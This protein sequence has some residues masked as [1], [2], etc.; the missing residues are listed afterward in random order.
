MGWGHW[1]RWR[2]WEGKYESEINLD[3]SSAE[4]SDAISITSNSL[5]PF[6]SEEKQNDGRQERTKHTL[7]T[8]RASHRVSNPL[9]SSPPLSLT[10][11]T[12]G[13]FVWPGLGNRAVS[14]PSRVPPLLWK[15]GTT[16]DCISGVVWENDSYSTNSQ[17]WPKRG[18]VITPHRASKLPPVQAL[19]YTHVRRTHTHMDRRSTKMPNKKHPDIS[20]LKTRM[21]RKER[22]PKEKKT[23]REHCSTTFPYIILPTV[24]YPSFTPCRG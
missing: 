7:F 4:F 16:D 23:T 1:G 15:V 6:L 18:P 8:A 14:G 24:H 13:C 22:T 5:F 20:C 12:A 9:S 3:R 11:F 10:W 21:T 17:G 19:I 2:K